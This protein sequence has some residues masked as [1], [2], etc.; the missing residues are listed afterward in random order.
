MRAVVFLSRLIGHAMHRL[1][2]LLIAVTFSAPTTWAD[3][4]AIDGLKLWLSAETGVTQTDRGRVVAWSD[5]SSSQLSM[6]GNSAPGQTA[7]VFVQSVPE[8]NGRPAI[9]FSGEG[10]SSFETADSLIGRV[11]NPFEL[12]TATIFLVVR[13]RRQSASSVITLSPT[14]DHATGRGGVGFRR[15]SN[16]GGWFA[17]HNAGDGNGAKAQTDEPILDDRFHV[18]AVTFDKPNSQIRMYVDG[19]DQRVQ[20]RARATEPMDPVKWVQLGGHGLLSPPGN[21]GSEWFFGGD[22]AEICVF[23][24]VLAQNKSAIVDL[25]PFNAVGWYLQNKYGLRGNFREA[26]IP[27][28][29][30]GDGIYDHIE[31]EFAFLNPADASD[32]AGDHDGDGLSNGREIQLRTNPAVQDTDGDGIFDGREVNQTKTSPLTS[33]TD[34]DGLADLRE[35]NMTG[36]DPLSPDSDKDRMSDGFELFFGTSPKEKTDTPSVSFKLWD[37]EVRMGT[38]AVAMDGTVLLFK[39]DQEKHLM[40]VKRS[41]DGGDTWGQD[42]VVGKAVRIDG[43]MSDGGRYRGP[44]VG[45]SDLGTVIVDENNGDILLFASSLKPAQ[46]IYRSQDHGKTWQTES[47]NIKPDSNGWLSAPL[48]SCDPGVTLKYGPKKG[49]LLA[50]TR[51]FV[52]YLNK[53]HGGRAFDKHYSNAIYSDDGGKTWTPSSPFPLGGTGEAGLAELK[54]GSIYYN[55]RTH[56]RPGNR[57]IAHS[58]DSGETWV[59]EH[60]DDELFDGPPDVY[61]CRAGLLRLPYDDQDV[62]LVSTPANVGARIDINVRAS[63]DGGRTWPYR[64]LVRPGPGNYTWMA[65]GRKGTPSEG[66]IYLL[67]GKDWMAR[68]NLPWVMQLSEPAD[69]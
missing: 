24:S 23:D 37:E 20:M 41:E 7:P 5:R 13:S 45:W 35:L 58:Y 50:P 55:S 61:G 66:M 6:D 9:R 51:V 25:N 67:S 12:N 26:I 18:L 4:K 34:K 10:G 47:T 14:A 49:R 46:I 30:D 64:R 63:F 39:D 56:M 42:I 28:D 68:F 31:D 65:A 38:L 53:G 16:A 43:D 11:T 69:K 15:G 48:A 62:L 33:D 32:A 27:E 21:S 1:L 57:R 22:I 2:L 3:P 60:E 59:E 36:T 29:T 17:V 40:L 44:H 19:T 8:L 52:E 54:D